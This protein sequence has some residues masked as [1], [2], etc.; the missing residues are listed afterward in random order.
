MLILLYFLFRVSRITSETISYNK[1][2]RRT[3]NMYTFLNK[4]Y[5]LCVGRNTD[6][7]TQ[8]ECVLIELYNKSTLF[9]KV[10]LVCAGVLSRYTVMR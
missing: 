2:H 6:T 9:T 8:T 1:Q 10:G 7:C 4:V 5:N 3:N